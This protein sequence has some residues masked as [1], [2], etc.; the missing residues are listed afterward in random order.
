MQEVYRDCGLRDC[1]DNNPHE[2]GGGK[3]G[4]QS[5]VAALDTP[6]D[7]RKVDGQFYYDIESAPHHTH[8]ELDCCF[9]VFLDVSKEGEGGL[10]DGQES[11]MMGDAQGTRE[12]RTIAELEDVVGA[13]RLR[14]SE[15][16]IAHSDTPPWSW[17]HICCQ[18][19][20]PD[21]ETH[22]RVDTDAEECEH[23]D[24]TNMVVGEGAPSLFV[25][26]ALQNCVDLAVNSFQ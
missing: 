15:Q 13:I 17:R 14:N 20:R 23:N 10:R 4:E 2:A 12:L 26:G 5:M 19:G 8:V 6:N 9:R 11:N 1:A 7:H 18:V 22:H 3:I 24:G 25:L 21:E 16:Q